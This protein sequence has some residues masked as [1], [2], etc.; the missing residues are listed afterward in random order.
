MTREAVLVS[1][2]PGELYTW[3]LPVLRELRLRDPTLK[4]SISLIPCQFASGHEVDIARGFG[5]DAVTTP[6]QYLRAAAGTGSAT[7]G[8]EPTA[9]S[10]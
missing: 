9:A 3:T 7:R 1:N 10:C 2:G 4:I 8:S 6:S 5:A